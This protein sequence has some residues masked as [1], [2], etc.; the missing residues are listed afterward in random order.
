MLQGA[1]I[2]RFAN[3]NLDAYNEK[4]D[5]VFVAIYIDGKGKAERY[6]LYQEE[7]GNSVR[8]RVRCILI[9]MLTCRRFIGHNE[10]SISQNQLGGWHLH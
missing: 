10:I 8:T 2:V 1:S 9:L 7:T 6:L 4:R 5:F 3:T